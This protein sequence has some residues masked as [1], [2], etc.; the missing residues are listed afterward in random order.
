MSEGFSDQILGGIGTL[1]R[2]FIRS[3]N[4]VT[5][6]TGWQITSDGNAE[7]NNLT[8]R[9]SSTGIIVGG[10]LGTNPEIKLD[11]TPEINVY[12][13]AGK[14]VCHIDAGGVYA[15]TDLTDLANSNWVKLSVTDPNIVNPAVLI[16]PGTTSSPTQQWKAGG[17][18]TV[19]VGT[20]APA[21]QSVELFS[22]VTT[23][24]GLSA[25]GGILVAGSAA[26]NSGGA[27]IHGFADQ[28]RLDSTDGTN[29]IEPEFMLG[30]IS[31]SRGTKFATG[32][33]TNITTSAQVMVLSATPANFVWHANRCYRVVIRGRLGT[34]VTDTLAIFKLLRGT[35]V[36]ASVAIDFGGL[37]A[38]AGALLPVTLEAY[39]M[40]NT[41]VDVTQQVQLSLQ[42][43][44][45]NT[46]TWDGGTMPRGFVIED[47]GSST[48][49]ATV[50]N[51]I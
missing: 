38:L 28:Y 49:Y 22:P 47:V 8:A 32:A 43:N 19:Q 14:L 50:A 5:G 27:F 10:P 44:N 26:D 17:L 36:A 20:G 45:A 42:A 30:G 6:S 3:K 25:A 37:R 23:A 15:D 1:I 46:V 7:F 11:T 40:N 31:H 33:T 18:R 12:D 13:A 48:D 9:G 4:Y 29:A 2:K 21:R 24:Q 39:I 16:Q 41:G 51:S 34:S 35:T